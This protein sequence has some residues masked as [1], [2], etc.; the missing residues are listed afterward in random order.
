MLG[1]IRQFRLRQ[2]MRAPGY[3]S[4]SPQSSV[5]TA[6]QSRTD[7]LT[8]EG[9]STGQG[10]ARRQG[11]GQ[12]GFLP[13]GSRAGGLSQSDF[14]DMCGLGVTNPGSPFQAPGLPFR[15]DL[16]ELGDGDDLFLREFRVAEH[17]FAEC[18]VGAGWRAAGAQTDCLT[19]VVHKLEHPEDFTDRYDG[20]MRHYGLEPRKINPS[21]PH[22]NGDCRAALL[23][24]VVA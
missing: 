10:V 8:S 7:R 4:S 15:V 9:M 13:S 6:A 14:T 21:C 22:E 20:L 12:G 3:S 5:R 23:H 19:A 18:A 24:G 1:T 11:T 16:L 17:W 2:R